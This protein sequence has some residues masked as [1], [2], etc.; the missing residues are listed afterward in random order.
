MKLKTKS[1][2]LIT[3]LSLATIIGF[4]TFTIGSPALACEKNEPKGPAPKVTG[5]VWYYNPYVGH[6]H[7]I[8]WAHDG[9]VVGKEDK[10][11]I[12]YWDDVG[13]SI[14]IIT[15][16]CYIRDATDGEPPEAYFISIFI[17]TTHP[18]HPLGAT[19]HSQIIDGGTPA[20]NG[21]VARSAFSFAE[22]EHTDWVY[23]YDGNIEI[24]TYE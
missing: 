9:S 19:L 11:E 6:G 5:D 23:Y 1:N 14:S 18:L 24:H 8:F 17:E 20:R 12:Y 7:T 16:V 10:G 15:E 4:L 22:L 2:L 21:D 3:I 13:Y